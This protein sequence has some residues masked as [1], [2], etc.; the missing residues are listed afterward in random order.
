MTK[1]HFS[2]QEVFKFGWSKTRQHAW[3]IVLTFIISS[4]ITGAVKFTPFTNII[5][6]LMAGLSIV[7]IS[8]QITRDHHF[9][10]RDLYLPLLSPN[11]VLKFI[12][13]TVLY[14][15][16]VS[17][18]TVLFIIPG[19]YIAVRFKFFPFVVIEHENESIADLIRLSYKTTAHNFWPVFFFLLLGCIINI[20]GALCFIIGL[21]ITIPTTIFA[22]AHMYDKLKAHAI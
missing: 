21:A 20:L 11:R 2:F 5:V 3:F 22:M 16:A 1:Q 13:L 19:I 17:I 4:I 14:I 15:L 7:S 9:T 8:L 6:C 12:A 10:F 18:G